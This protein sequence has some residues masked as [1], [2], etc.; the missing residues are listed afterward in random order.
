M[1]KALIF[2]KKT[3]EE[4]VINHFKEFTLKYI[5][6]IS[7]REIK[8]A[9][10]E[11]NLLLEEKYSYYCELEADSKDHMNELMNSKAGKELNKDMM[12][13]HPFITVIYVNYNNS[14]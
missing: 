4:K 12:E 10:V 2:L 1:F 13:F 7:G 8:A 9:A 14:L 6:E 5:S 3:N 11:S